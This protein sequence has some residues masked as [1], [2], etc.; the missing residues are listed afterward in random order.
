LT[1]KPD[2]K[3][4]GEFHPS[5][6]FE[7]RRGAAGATILLLHYT[8]VATAAKAIDWLSRPESKV[9]AHYVLD[10]A[11]FLT[12]LVAEDMRAWH[13]GLAVWAGETDINS[14][15]IGI[16]IQNKGHEAGSPDFPE[17]QLKVLEALCLEIVARHGIR[18]ERVLGHSDVAP[19]RKMDP[20]EKFPWARLA[21]AGIGHWVAPEPVDWADPGIARD[22]AGPLVAAVQ[23]MLAS[24]G[25]GIEATGGVD[26]RTEFVIKAFQRHFRPERVDGRIDQSTITTLE[27][28]TA[29]LPKVAGAT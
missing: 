10:E 22:A 4:V 17:A 29:A 2:S 14:A 24:Y 8:G 3:L 5:P 1:A 16:E 27:R 6:N 18:P 7:P 26:P 13:A 21:A 12:Q 11:G 28:L 19:T 25:Y 20:G 15:S 23:T 9:S